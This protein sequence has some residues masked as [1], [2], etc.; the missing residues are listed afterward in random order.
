MAQRGDAVLQLLLQHQGE[1]AT[2]HMAA[3][4]LV[5]LVE[6]RARGEQA[7]RRSERA[8][9]HPQMFVAKHGFERR[10]IGVRAE[11]EDSVELGV[12]LRLG[13]IDDEMVVVWR[14]EKA[15]IALVADKGFIAFLQLTLE[16]GQDRGS[17]G[18]VLLHLFAIATD[19]VTPP[20]QHDRLG[21]VVD[22]LAP[23]GDSEWD[24][25]SGIG[26]HEVSHQFVAAL[27][28]AENIAKPARF[29]FG[30]GLG[31]DHAAIGDD[32]DAL[33]GK[34]LAQPI[35]HRNE[36]ADIG[37][38]PWPHF[39]ANWSTVAIEQ[40][41]ENHLIEVRPMVF[42]EAALSQRLATR[43]LEIE[44]GRVHEHEV[45]LA[46]QIAPARE[47]LLFDDVLQAAWR[48]ERGA[49]PV[50][51]RPAPR[52]ARPSRDKGDAGRDPRR[53]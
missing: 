40:H 45:E 8:L 51:L 3:N 34:A 41:G 49:A 7:F 24:E 37:R 16:R 48:E 30:D 20:G 33:N 25:G 23:L 21:F 12:L 42:G 6:N 47:Q 1:K 14:R 29:E 50:D 4:G 5:E 17:G 27:A 43:S 35:D 10:E 9:H 53:H 22:L 11:H 13:A 2:R 19:D 38:V 18:G 26:E 31:A 46:E 28:H 36:A 52:P 32:A 44:A 39:C 15:P